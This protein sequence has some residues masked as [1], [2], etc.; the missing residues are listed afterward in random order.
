MI[1]IELLLLQCERVA[2]SEHKSNPFNKKQIK[3]SIYEMLMSRS[4]V[5]LFYCADLPNQKWK[6]DL[7]SAH[8]CTRH[9]HRQRKTQSSIII[10][11]F[12]NHPSQAA[13]MANIFDW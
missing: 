6:L 10:F 4:F 5:M 11:F 2:R 7:K 9:T 3:R 13:L 12:F 1:S 8:Q